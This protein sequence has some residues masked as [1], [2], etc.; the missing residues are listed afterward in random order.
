MPGKHRTGT[1]FGSSIDVKRAVLLLLL[2]AACSGSRGV[3]QGMSWSRPVE[4]ARGEAVR[5]PWRQNESDYRWVDDATVDLAGGAAVVAWADHAR[6]DIFVQ[7]YDR[8]GVALLRGPTNVSRSPATFSW[9]PRI[10][11]E[12]DRVH[13]LWQEIVFSG[14]SHG[15][16]IF[17]A[18]SEDGAHS[19]GVPLNLSE[20]REGDGKGRLDAQRWDNGSL[21]LAAAGRAIY[22][23]WTEYEGALWLRA[24]RDGGTSFDAAVRVA[25]TRPLPARA[26]SV[27]ASASGDV[28]DVAWTVGEDASADV[29]VASSSD[30]GRSFGPARV[31]FAS[32][33]RADAP[34]IAVDRSGTL[35]LVAMEASHRVSYVRG[36]G[37]VFDAPRV[38]SESGSSPTVS[39]DAAGR[40]HVLWERNVA[41]DGRGRG[42]AYVCS[43]DGGATFG[44]PLEVPHIAHPSLGSNGS[45]QGML[46]DKLAVDADG[47]VAIVNSTFNPDRSSHV[48]LVRAD[49]R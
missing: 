42:L 29:H 40:V 32:V 14:G 13:V 28:V 2:L 4:V 16:E 48:W 49:R 12:G 34:Q 38:L 20:S 36:R 25:G 37:E 6:K 3:R 35:H 33:E 17:Y 15:G 45:Q 7:R 8:A 18:R 24:S 10:A 5:G 39:V 9:L 43:Q 22:A 47:A 21:D 30:G 31:A 44:A 46:V 27:T 11:V 26:P 41:A 19:F 1:V 23:V